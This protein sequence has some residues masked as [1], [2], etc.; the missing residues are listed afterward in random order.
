MS[1]EV[2]TITP[3]TVVAINLNPYQG[4]KL[5]IFSQKQCSLGVGCNQPKS[6]S[7]IETRVQTQNSSALPKVAINLNPYQGLKPN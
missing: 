4:L 5:P 1:T 2:S 6:L 3:E 7:G